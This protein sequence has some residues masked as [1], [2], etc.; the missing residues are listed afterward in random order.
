MRFLRICS[1]R[2]RSPVAARRRGG[3]SVARAERCARARSA[4]R[5]RTTRVGRARHGEGVE[6][7]AQR[8][9]LE[10][11]E[12]EQVADEL[13]HRR[14]DVAAALQELALGRRR[15]RPA[16][17]GSARDSRRGRS[18]G[19]AARGRRWTRSA[20]ARRPVP[21]ASPAPARWR[22]RGRERQDR[23][24]A[25]RA[26]RRREALGE[27]SR[28]RRVGEVEA[29]H[30]ARRCRARDERVRAASR[31][32]R[33]GSPRG[34]AVPVP[35]AG[36]RTAA[37]GAAARSARERGAVASSQ[38]AR[39]SA[40]RRRP[41]C[42]DGDGDP[43]L[44]AVGKDGG[45]PRPD[46]V[47][48]GRRGCRPGAPRRNGRRRARRAQR[49]R[50]RVSWWAMRSSAAATGRARRRRRAAGQPRCG[51]RDGQPDRAA[52]GHETMA[53]RRSAESH[54]ADR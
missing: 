4:S 50:R 13:G 31:T 24:A 30:R 37:A 21:A 32:A 40:A 7:Q 38:A 27:G 17:R 2:R 20:S 42:R 26:Y 52:I 36:Q 1:T 29:E 25:W 45:P 47:G 33:P 22:A 28:G 15:P 18:A 9:R 10:P 11:R 49:A 3:R 19:S 34:P 43:P 5:R 16:R 51:R 39:A 54:P 53:R 48:Q 6:L 12:L 35:L 46:R 23:R 8:A 41:R 44:A 14:D